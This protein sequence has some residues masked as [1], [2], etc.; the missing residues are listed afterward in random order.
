MYGFSKS[1]PIYL[2]KTEVELGHLHCL[3]KNNKEQKGDLG[4]KVYIPC[5]GY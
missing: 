1:K 5:L 3:E 4:R 2:G